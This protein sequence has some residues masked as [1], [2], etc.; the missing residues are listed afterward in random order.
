LLRAE[1]WFG[2]HHEM[3]NS[4]DDLLVRRTGRLYFDIESIAPALDIILM[5]MKNY[6]GWNESRT[7]AELERMELLLKDA[8]TYY[9]KEMEVAPVV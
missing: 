6:L 7:Q 4:I 5:D 1:T 8:T 9:E 2:V 3:V